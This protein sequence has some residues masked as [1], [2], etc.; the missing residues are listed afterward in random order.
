MLDAMVGQLGLA[1]HVD[2]LGRVADAERLYGDCHVFVSTSRTESFGFPLLEAM[3]SGVP[4][5]ASAIPSSI[6]VL[7]GHGELFLPGDPTAAANAVRR[8]LDLSAADR[9]ERVERA[10]RWA[11]AYHW[12]RNARA[13]AAIIEDSTG[14]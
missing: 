7:A 5:I 12:E 13:I 11:E 3:A 14:R 1:R 8:V 6:E 2:L 4:I 10:R 9:L